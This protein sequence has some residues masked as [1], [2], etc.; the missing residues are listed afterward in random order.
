MK[1]AMQ[2]NNPAEALRDYE[3]LEKDFPGSSELPD[4]LDDAVKQLD[5]LQGEIS[6]AKLNYELLEKN[7]AKAIA[8][9]SADQAKIL[10]DAKNKDE[11]TAMTA[12]KTAAADG[13]KFFP[14]FPNSKEALDGLQAIVVAERV[15]LTQLQASMREGFAAW[16]DCSRLLK[17][18]NLAAARAK[19]ELSQK[20]WPAN[21]ENAKLKAQ[22]D[23]AQQAAQAQQEQPKP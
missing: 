13:S 5:L 19:L 8:S 4:A 21:S 22:L 16:R 3:Q 20:L 12:R 18:G 10:T 11:A 2:T 15:R 23:Q 6:A 7:R 9:S 17:E 1:A 14:V